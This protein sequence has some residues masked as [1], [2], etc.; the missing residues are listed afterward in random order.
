MLNK[1]QA[2]EK[3]LAHPCYLDMGAPKLASKWGT[4]PEIVR[5]AR[6]MARELQ[7]MLPKVPKPSLSFEERIDELGLELKDVKNVKFWQNMAGENR[8]SI[9]TKDEWYQRGIDLKDSLLEDIKKYKAPL[10]VPTKKDKDDPNRYCAV[11]NIYDAHID[12]LCLIDETGVSFDSSLS[13]NCLLFESYFDKLLSQVLMY[14]PETI[15]FPVG[16]DFF[17]TNGASNATK[18]GTPQ[19]V[20]TKFQEAFKQGLKA[21]RRC[22]DKAAQHSKVIVPVIAGNHDEDQIFYLGEILEALYEGN[23]NVQILNTR[24]ARK[25]VRFGRNLFGFAHGDKEHKNISNLPLL[26]AE[27]CKAEWAST[28]FREWFLGDRHHKFE[29]KFMRT[30]DFVGS[31]V[32][33]LRSVTDADKWHHSS[34][35]IGIP[36]TAEAFVYNYSKG[37]E[38]NFLSTIK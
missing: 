35:Y 23:T 8:F 16:N 3:F 36:K 15:Y 4:T 5:E 10:F 1:E 31:T 28:D 27:E 19:D 29:F 24:H 21:L 2:L 9:N 22:I 33:F 6:A 26:M 34:G 14:S 17:N 12:K 38:H 13:M 11:I 20:V 7:V 37:L 25:Y 18:K 30:K 32:R